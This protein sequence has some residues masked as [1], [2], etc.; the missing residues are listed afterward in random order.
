[1]KPRTISFDDGSFKGFRGKVLLV[2]VVMRGKSVVEKVVSAKITI[3][4]DDA[5]ETIVRLI[6][7]CPQSFNVVFLDGLAFGGFN[8]VDLHEI[9]ERT[10]VPVIAVTRREPNLSAIKDALRNVP[11]GKVKWQLLRNLGAPTRYKKLFFQY[12]GTDLETAKKFLDECSQ[13]SV[14]EGLRLAHL[15]ASGVSRSALNVR[16]D[17]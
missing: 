1:M 4:G 3:D 8:V 2:G 16:E 13:Y 11:G 14:P 6:Q 12:V 9:Y 7:S 17:S 10:S 15:I 5:T